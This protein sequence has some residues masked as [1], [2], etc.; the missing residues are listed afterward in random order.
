LAV[1]FAGAFFAVVFAAAAF[2]VLVFLAAVAV[3]AGDFVAV[4]AVLV[5]FAGAFL[6][7]LDV[8]ALVLA[9]L[10]LAVLA[11]LAGE[12]VAALFFAAAV[13][14]VVFFAAVDLAAVDFAAVDFAAVD[15]AAVDF[16]AV[17]FA[18]A[19]FAAVDFPAV[20]FAAV[21]FAGAFAVDVFLVTVTL[22]ADFFAGADLV[23]VAAVF[24]AAVREPAAF[25]APADAFFAAAVP[26]PSVSFGSFLAPETTFLRSAPAVNF[27]TAVFFART[28]SPVRGL[29]T[30]R[31]ARTRFSK[32]PKPVMPTFSPFATSRVIVSS[33]DSKA[34]AA[35]RRFPSNRAASA[36]MSCD[37]FTVVPSNEPPVV[38]PV[39]DFHQR[40]LGIRRHGHNDHGDF[41]W[42]FFGACR[43]ANSA[44]P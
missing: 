26:A 13:D 31:A 18:A 16:A 2:A 35:W 37:L 6:V 27:G 28:R 11:F 30:M 39:L 7:V 44:Q 19:D 1:F 42:I 22:A 40:T 3:F 36:S 32:E 38:E 41:P 29:R 4:L 20:D 5:D 17:D 10:V 33:T 9:A 24:L 12:V 14:A 15:F 23:A 21:D 8:A 34:W 25:A 43:G